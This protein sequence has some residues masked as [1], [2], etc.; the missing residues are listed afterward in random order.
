MSISAACMGLDLRDLIFRI[1]RTFG[2]RIH[3]EE[4]Q[5]LIKNHEMPDIQVEDLY[6]FILARAPL[7][8]LI[9][10]DRDAEALWAMYQR[11]V[12]DALGVEIS[13]VAKG[14]RLIRDLRAE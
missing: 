13:E 7:S 6:E 12:S 9:D 5:R 8:G 10:I 1:E 3:R 14:R 11:D 4:F 2:V